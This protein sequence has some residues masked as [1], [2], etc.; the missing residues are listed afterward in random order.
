MSAGARALALGL[1]LAGVAQA[2]NDAAFVS[3]SVPI[4]MAPSQVYA[5]S[6]TFHNTGTTTWTPG[7]FHRLGTQNPQD[8]TL[9]TGSTRVMLPAGTSVAP[10]ASYTFSFNV[11]APSTPGTY[12]FQWKMLQE[13]VEWFGVQS[14]SVPVTVGALDTSVNFIHTDHLDTPRLVA[15]SSGTAVWKWG[16]QEPF[17]VNPADENPS[18]LGSF[19]FNLRFPGQ[20][21]D[22]ETNLA[23]NWMREFD[24]GTGR[25][26]QS[27][28]LGLDGGINTYAY[29]GSYSIGATDPTGLFS[30]LNMCAN[31]ANAA[32]CAAAGIGG[33]A[34][35]ATSLATNV[36]SQLSQN[37]CVNWNQAATAT[38][39]GASMGVAI[40]PLTPMMSGGVS[41]LGAATGPLNAWIRF[42][43]SFSISK[44][45]PTTFS[46]KYGSNPYYVQQI[47]NPTLQSI[48]IQLRSSSVP[49][50]GRA[51]GDPGHIH[52]RW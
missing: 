34:G 38:A 33:I 49:L 12:Q 43:P 10:G 22:K 46:I 8:N 40:G 9:W 20:Y 41:N 17:G 37:A 1:L 35:G 51:F 3:Q 24:P 52:L 31:P 27:D 48:N 39:M 30:T 44:N 21:A 14:T 2:A 16:Q 25:Y 15:N 47:G 32:A 26:I 23:Q 42:G 6:V 45:A 11:T 5:V 4:A 50:P 36:A 7:S 28:P 29:V 18:G 13:S 19:E